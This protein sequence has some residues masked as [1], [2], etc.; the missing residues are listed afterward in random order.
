MILLSYILL[1]HPDWEGAEIK[2]FAVFPEEEIEEE[3]EK[4]L[5]LVRS[6]RLPISA[7]N[8]ELIVRRPGSKIRTLI[9]ERSRDADLT[10]IGFVGE[11]VRKRKTEAFECAGLG[12][13]LFVSSTHEI[14]LYDEEEDHEAAE[15]E[16]TAGEQEASGSEEAPAPG[17][18]SPEE[19]EEDEDAIKVTDSDTSNEDSSDGGTSSPRE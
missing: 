5:S 7:K 13:V 19:A 11:E 4:M 9:E 1:G 18:T 10:M 2:L 8:I 15:R 3:K 16:S 6:G 12:N 17:R 14:E